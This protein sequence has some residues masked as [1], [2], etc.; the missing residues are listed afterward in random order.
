VQFANVCTSAVVVPGVR[1]TLSAWLRTQTLTTDQG[2]RIELSW[3]ENSA[4]ATLHTPDL[5]GTEPW[6]QVR[7]PF[8]PGSGVRQVYVCVVRY[9]SD[10][11]ENHIQGVAWVDDVALVPV[12]AAASNP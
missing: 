5:H 3:I 10:K 11:F 8:T 7:V 2:V 12:S 4:R 6:T 9:P 1:Y